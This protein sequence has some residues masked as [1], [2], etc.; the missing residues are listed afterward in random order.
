MVGLFNNLAVL[1][2]MNGGVCVKRIALIIF[3]V[4]LL[5]SNIEVIE[6][7][8][9][10]DCISVSADSAALICSDTGK[11]LYAKNDREKR[12]MAS[13]TKIMTCITLLENISDLGKKATVSKYASSMPD[14]QLNAIKGDSFRIKDL[15]Y[16][17]MLESLNLADRSSYL[18]KA[19]SY[20]ADFTI[21][22]RSV[23]IKCILG[24]KCPPSVFY[25]TYHT[26]NITEGFL[27]SKKVTTQYFK[28][29][30]QPHAVLKR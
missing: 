24:I 13:T 9:A 6:V 10:D 2:M 30:P 8:S 16:S 4:L 14:V 28:A 22:L 12:P 27:F 5:L 7:F 26:D 15:L 19:S 1:K 29:R 20:V 18:A 11:V 23:E 21:A 3:V 25:G 17:L